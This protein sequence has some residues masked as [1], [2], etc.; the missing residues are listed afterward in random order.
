MQGPDHL[1]SARI[2]VDCYADTYGA[3]KAASRAATTALNGHRG[4]GFRGVFWEGAR[5]SREGGSN[6]AD[7]PY[8]VSL[9][10][11]VNWRAEQ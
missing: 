6:E 4:G 10:F 9:D 2:Q 5:D 1:L 8:R 11:M 3:A 7:R